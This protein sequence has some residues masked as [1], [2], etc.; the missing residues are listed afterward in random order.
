M[1]GGRIL[2]QGTYGCVFQPAL[3]CRG[4]KRN[5]CEN[6][7]GKI[8]SKRDAKNE[9]EISEILHAIQDFKSYTIPVEKE[10]CSPRA[11]SK[12]TEKDIQECDLSKELDIK[13]ELYR[14]NDLKKICNFLKFRKCIQK[15]DIINSKSLT[16]KLR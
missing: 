14:F 8:T 11:K 7:V 4:K 5:I 12:Q 10:K 16:D 3:V 2:G 9:L 1:L 6:M 13:I 15:I